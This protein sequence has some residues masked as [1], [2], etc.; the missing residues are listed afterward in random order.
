MAVT[1]SK[2]LQAKEKSEVT[3]PAEQ[4]RPGLV[5]TPAVDIFETD[6]GITLLADMPGVKAKDLNIDLHENVPT[7]DSDVKTPEGDS[8]VDVITEY[9]TGKYYRQF[10]LS[11]LIDQAKI[12]AELKDGVLR[13][14]LPKVEAATPRKIAVKGSV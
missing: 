5:F 10:T 2:A 8:E 6:K 14:T 4:T 7:L 1:K 3:T 13:L 11:Q 9:R 12:N